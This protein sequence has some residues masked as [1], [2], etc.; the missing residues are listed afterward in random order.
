MTGPMDKNK[1]IQSATKFVQKGQ[2]DKAIKEY[3]RI[4]DA[5]PKDIRIL[6]KVGELHQKRGE[7]SQAAVSLRKVA[8]SYAA[9]GFFLKAAAVYKQVLKLN[10]ALLDVN[11]RLAELYQ[12]LGLM[13]DATQQFQLVAAAHERQGNHG[14]ALEVFRRLVDLDPENVASRLRLADALAREGLSPD[15]IAE[16]QRV[17]RQLKDNNR[18]DEYLKVGERLAVQDPGNIPFAREL[19][20]AYLARGDP[21]RAL[22]KLQTCF[23][24]D[25]QDV[26]TLH[27]LAQAF[28]ELGQVAKTVSVYK[29]LAKICEQ[30]DRLEEARSVWRQVLALVPDD[31]EA[32]ERTGEARPVAAAPVRHT[33]VGTPAVRPPP[34]QAQP[35]AQSPP[36]VPTARPAPTPATIPKLLTETEVYFKYGLIEKAADHLRKVLAMDPDHLGAHDKSHQLFLAIGDTR[37]AAD[38]LA[39]CARLCL[40][41]GDK[42]RAGEYFQRLEEASPGHPKLE[43]LAKSLGIQAGRAQPLEEEVPGGEEEAELLVDEL[44]A[45]SGE[46]I[47]MDSPEPMDS[48]LEPPLLEGDEQF[49]EDENADEPLGFGADDERIDATT[50]VGVPAPQPTA[51][52]PPSFE[53]R[54]ELNEAEFLIDQGLLDEAQDVLEALRLDAVGDGGLLARLSQLQRRVDDARGTGDSEPAIGIPEPEEA[55]STA[56]NSLP[57]E[58]FQYSVQDVLSEFK[59]GVSRTVRPEDFETHYD[60][61]IAYREMGLLD[62]AI[63]EFRTALSRAGGQPKEGDCLGMIGL[64]L[65]N[66]GAFREAADTFERALGVKAIRPEAAKSLHFE[67]GLA[68]EAMGDLDGA[69]EAFERV[70]RLDSGFRNVAECLAR[71]SREGAIP[72]KANPSDAAAPEEESAKRKRKIGYV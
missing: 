24:A 53:D 43:E 23:K 26:E 63:G 36:P 2:I 71:L 11:F 51:A 18:I 41:Q 57:D 25:P 35:Q 61:G 16:Y 42:K 56:V 38:E 37:R 70:A 30:T 40:G 5:D 58:D 3:Q 14:A 50:V 45:A 6:L 59:K 48:E 55:E 15:S 46:A 69:R 7:N 17:A 64:C 1:L 21:K 54:E 9:D 44:D 72:E 27:L 31:A 34:R 20:A 47:L 67:I 60:L 22:S 29:E 13:S 39:E 32:R 68:R 52:V 4:L 62:E 33:P 12:Q 28:K 8:E 66:K 19:A 49:V 65:A 10:P